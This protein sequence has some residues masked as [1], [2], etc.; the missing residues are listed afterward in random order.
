MRHEEGIVVGNIEDKENPTN[1]LAR[2]LIGGFDRALIELIEQVA[3][4]SIHE[5]GCGE[6]RLARLL[7]GR[8]DTPYRAT[9]FSKQVIREA[10]QANRNPRLL[11]VTRSIYDLLPAEDSASLILC[12][13]VLE[14]LEHPTQ[15]LKALL[16]LDA[17]WYIFSVPREPVWRVLNVCRLRYLPQWGNTPGHLNHWSQDAFIRFLETHGF[18]TTQKRAPFPWTMTLCRKA[19]SPV[20]AS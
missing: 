8:I 17:P 4:S 20:F 10:Q 7:T 1:L 15:A 13:E 12:C 11:Y 19:P 3:P 9:D 5:V 6:G 2:R 18:E 16:R 14:H